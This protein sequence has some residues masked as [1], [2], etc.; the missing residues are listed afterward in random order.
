MS[1]PTEMTVSFG[2]QAYLVSGVGGG[3]K[4]ICL[5]RAYLSPGHAQFSELSSAPFSPP[6]GCP[7]PMFLMLLLVLLLLPSRTD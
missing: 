4:R 3:V 7:P 5:G 2:V 1:V 6:S